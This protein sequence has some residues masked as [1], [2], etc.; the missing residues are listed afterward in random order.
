MAWYM[1]RYRYNYIFCLY[2]FINTTS[3]QLQ[4][5]T[6]DHSCRQST[7]KLWSQTSGVPTSCVVKLRKQMGH[8]S[9]CP[10]LPSDMYAEGE[11]ALDDD[12][13]PSQT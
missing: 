9:D 10:S 1:I 11:A 6:L 8:F 4:L 7:Q 2:S 12:A 5:L 3:M 13:S